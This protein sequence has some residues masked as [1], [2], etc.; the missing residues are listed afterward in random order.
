VDAL[1]ILQDD[2]NDKAFE[3]ARLCN[4]YLPA[5][6]IIAASKGSDVEEGFLH[7]VSPKQDFSAALIY[8][9]QGLL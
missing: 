1:C 5:T 9:T 2:E 8:G 7:N 6:V 4:V 3:I